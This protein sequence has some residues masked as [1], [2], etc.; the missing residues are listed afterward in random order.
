MPIQVILSHLKSDTGLTWEA[1]ANAVGVSYQT[2][3]RIRTGR[4]PGIP[5]VQQRIR[6]LANGTGKPANI[7]RA[8]DL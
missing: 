2:L 5:L 8:E 4:S 1:L 7:L 3:Y 6:D